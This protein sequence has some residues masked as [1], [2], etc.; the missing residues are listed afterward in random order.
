M[1]D[2]AAVDVGY[3]FQKATHSGFALAMRKTPG[4][5]LRNHEILQEEALNSHP[6][7]RFHLTSCG[8]S[9]K[10]QTR[11]DKQERRDVQCLLFRIVLLLLNPIIQL[12]T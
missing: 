8:I 2:A 9:L 6:P 4:P 10:H 7:K 1:H 3:S 11:G 12:T 5:V